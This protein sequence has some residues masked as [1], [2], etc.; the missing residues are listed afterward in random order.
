[1]NQIICYIYEYKGEKKIHNSGFLKIQ[2]RGHTLLVQ[3][4]LKGLALTNSETLSLSIFYKDKDIAVT[5]KLIELP[6]KNKAI[7]MQFPLTGDFFPERRH[8]QECDGF[9]LRGPYEETYVSAWSNVPVDTT[10]IR[11]FHETVPEAASE[12]SIAEETEKDSTAQEAAEAPENEE[13]LAAQIS[14]QCRKI[15]RSELSVLP[16]RSWNLANNSFLLHGCHNYHHLLLVESDDAFILGVPGLYDKKEAHA[17]D[18]F[19]FP[20]FSAEYISE[21]DLS[22]DERSDTPNFGYWCRSISKTN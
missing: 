12:S 7:H 8:L 2:H 14:P 17:A 21:M 6:V 1:M 20:L 5:K 4:H 19:G 13:I 22:K 15:S 16:R 3:M 10:K 9:L 11:E 18:L